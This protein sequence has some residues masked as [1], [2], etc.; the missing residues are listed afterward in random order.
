MGRPIAIIG[1]P[2]SLGAA[3]YADGE[4]RHLDRAPRVLRARGVVDRLKADDFGDVVPPPYRD[5][6]RPSRRVRNERE[7][8]VYSRQLADRVAMAAARGRFA[9]VLGGDCSVVLGCLLGARQTAKRP[10]LVYIDA[11]PDFATLEESPTGAAA[12]MGLAL[13]TGREAGPLAQLAGGRPLVEGRHVALVGRRDG[14]DPWCAPH[15][16]KSAAILDLADMAPASVLD[17]VAPP[18]VEGFWIQLDV[19]V[20]NP[21]VMPAVAAPEPGGPSGDELAALLRPLVRHPRAVGMSLTVYDPALDPDRS[22][23]RRLITL[24]DATFASSADVT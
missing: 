18:D 12:T 1:A 17:R 4:A 24:L 10:G 21:A 5:Y 9:L 11:H 23:A 2:S 3:P 22:S 15:A 19:D 7:V 13:A 6:E 16:L 8:V 20:L 14:G